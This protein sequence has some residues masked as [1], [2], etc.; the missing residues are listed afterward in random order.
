[1]FSFPFPLRGWGVGSAEAI[2]RVRG[3]PGHQT[4]W[5]CVVGPWPAI[6]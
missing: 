3:E 5:R 4:F 2:L 1:M 6:C